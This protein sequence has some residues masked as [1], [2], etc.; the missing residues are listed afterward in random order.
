MDP[1]LKKIVNTL[2]CPIC[3]SQI[4]GLEGAFYCV[5]NREDYCVYISHYDDI[6]RVERESIMIFEGTRLYHVLQ[7]YEE[8]KNNWT[9]FYIFP[10]D[11]E[12][13]LI[14]GKA[15]ENYLIGTYE[16]S[17]FD[18]QDTNREKILDRLKTILVFQ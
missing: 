12:K 7:V 15:D 1:I 10:I 11:A 18:F 9:E 13:R 6:I 4:E 8:D 3:G 2:K 17:L 16:Q 14:E 5:Y